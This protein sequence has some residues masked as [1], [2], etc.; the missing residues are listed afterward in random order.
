[1]KFWLFL[2]MLWAVG[3]SAQTA[4]HSAK[5]KPLDIYF[6]DTEGGQATLFVAPSGESMLVD[7]GF[8]G[9]GGMPVVPGAPAIT[10][11][12][13]RI[14]NALKLA[15]VSVL[16]TVVITHYHGDHVGSAAELAARIPIRRFIDHGPYTVELQPGR[17]AGFASYQ[18]VRD[19]AHAIT[20]K[21][22]DRIAVAGLDVQ[23]VSS[24][25][26][27]ITKPM[28]GAPGAGA[29]NPSCRGAQK[30]DQDPTPENFESVGLV[31]RYGAFRLLD[32]GDLTW[33]QEHDLMC[34]NNLLGLFDVFHT[35]RH[36]D[37]HAGAPQLVH[38][39]HARVAVMNNGERKGGDPSYWQIVHQAPGLQ[40][41]WQI[42]RS[43]AGGADHNSPEQF[44]ANLNETD[45][46]HYIKM[47][48]RADGSFT[49]TNERNGFTKDYPSTK[50]ASTKPAS[51]A[52]ASAVKP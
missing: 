11:D 42:H 28:E 10:R 50:N 23:V 49:M 12:A 14:M 40:D 15:N 43:A 22:G 46:G 29:P 45:H 39:I 1:M 27:L 38:A 34:P 33:N 8:G 4:P 16:D 24:A 51:N 7:T 19:K 41:F 18:P 35:T 25:G 44:L 48:V 47:S 32:L 20:A 6:L 30:K 3:T 37:P 2:S 17:V 31:V 21:P 26:A 13:D 52:V 9:N 5:A 36:G